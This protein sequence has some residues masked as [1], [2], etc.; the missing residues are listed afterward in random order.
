M[1]Y[2]CLVIIA[3][4]WNA[5]ASD[6]TLLELYDKKEEVQ[7]P[8]PKPQERLRYHLGKLENLNLSEQDQIKSETFI[9]V[10][11]KGA[12]LFNM[13]K[14]DQI[15]VTNKEIIVRVF[16]Q[17]DFLGHQILLNKDGSITYKAHYNDIEHIDHVTNMHE[18][19]KRY[20]PVKQ[21]IVFNHEDK[22]FNIQ[23]D[24]NFSIGFVSSNYTKD[25]VD[26]SSL[27]MRTFHYDSITFANWNF[28]VLL[29]LFLG[30]ESSNAAS[31][32]GFTIM[33][34]SLMIGPAVKSKA[35][36]WG[37][38]PV[39][40]IAALKASI[41]SNLSISHSSGNYEYRANKQALKAGL[42][43][44]KDSNI[45]GKVLFGAHL[46]RTWIKAKSDRY[47]IDLDRKNFFDDSFLVSIGFQKD[48]AW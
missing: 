11:R 36:N 47:E 10:I 33:D 21:K 39:E 38:S 45:F 42:Q 2:L 19:P 8:A 43:T 25:I 34:R 15:E 27:S 44:V 18:S 35:F 24:F 29:G 48:F 31:S 16:K 28:D 37:Q 20:K 46:Q 12:I 30:V 14:N 41:L 23:N 17:K 3:T 26:D 1:K 4:T 32:R 13:S 5:F 22:K 7:A 9:G 6:Q 40:F